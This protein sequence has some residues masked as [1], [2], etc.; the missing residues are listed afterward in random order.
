MM[1]TCGAIGLTYP[2]AAAPAR[3]ER[4]R[5]QVSRPIMERRARGLPTWLHRRIDQDLMSNFGSNSWFVDELY[6]RYLQ[7]P[8]SVSDV[9]REFFADYKGGNG[10]GVAVEPSM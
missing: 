5:W 4:Y 3:A 6:A 7:D 8:S 10:N 9:W 1:I 2:S